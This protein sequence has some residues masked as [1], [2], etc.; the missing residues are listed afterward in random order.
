MTE[1]YDD[2]FLATFRLVVLGRHHLSAEFSVT[3]EDD[4]GRRYAASKP[5]T[6]H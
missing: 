6:K 2:A 1:R 3:G 4:G 5:K